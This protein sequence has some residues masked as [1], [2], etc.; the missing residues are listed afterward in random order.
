MQFASNHVGNSY[1]DIGEE[2]TARG[3][4]SQTLLGTT[5]IGCTIIQE[6]S[7]VKMP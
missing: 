2:E 4:L 5:R 6:R 3:V 1:C 7:P